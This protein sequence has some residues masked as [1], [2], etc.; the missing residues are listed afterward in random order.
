MALPL[1]PLSR[2]SGVAIEGMDL[3]GAVA[4][5]AFAGIGRAD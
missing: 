1:R 3:S 2:H 4:D 5:G